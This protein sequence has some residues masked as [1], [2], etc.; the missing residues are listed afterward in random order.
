MSRLAVDKTLSPQRHRG[1]KAAFSK[2][3]LIVS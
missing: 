1:H 3:I 2:H